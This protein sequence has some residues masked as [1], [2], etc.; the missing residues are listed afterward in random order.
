MG[1]F[2]RVGRQLITFSWGLTYNLFADKLLKFDLFPQSIYEMRECLIS[3]ECNDCRTQGIEQ[4]LPGTRPL[5]VRILS[6]TPAPS[7]YDLNIRRSRRCAARYPAYIHEDRL[8]D[9]DRFH[10][11]RHFRQG[12]LYFSSEEMG[13]GWQGKPTIRRF[14]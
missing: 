11:D 9:L 12:H 3:A 4:R 10:H 14:I 1:L 2:Q 5:S 8:G 6:R 7:W 13:I